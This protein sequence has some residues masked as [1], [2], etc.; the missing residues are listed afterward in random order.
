[1]IDRVKNVGLIRG[2]SVVGIQATFHSA[3]K[4]VLHLIKVK[5]HLGKI[6]IEKQALELGAIESIREHLQKNTPVVLC[7]DGKNVIHKYVSD[8]IGNNPLD[9]V[10][11]NA[12][13]DDFYV[14]KTENGDGNYLSVIRREVLDNFV[15]GLH[16]QGII[17]AMISLGPFILSGTKSL[18]AE[19]VKFNTELW[20]IAASNDQVTYASALNKDFDFTFLNGENIRACLMPAYSLSICYLANIGVDE[21]EISAKNK[22]NFLYKRAVWLTGWFLLI[23]VFAILLINFMVFSHYNSKYE[24]SSNMLQQHQSL[25]SR[26]DELKEQYT[27]KRKFIERSGLLNSSRFSFYCDRIAQL[28]P[29]SIQLTSLQVFPVDSKIRSDKPIVYGENK[30]LVAGNCSN[31]RYFNN[32]KDNLK[33]EPWLRDIYINQ[34]GQEQ[35]DKPIFFEII[36]D[37]K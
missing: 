9:L 22:D 19:S 10:L 20:A 2:N 23:A 15:D 37:I 7:I 32:W 16:K 24:A 18:F 28:V 4:F 33:L 12:S 30:I 21:I 31:S 5:K 34:F 27:K 8:N 1:M 35:P 13:K 14:Q 17:P 26:N 29:D 3:D 25:L 36:L 6:S 11:P